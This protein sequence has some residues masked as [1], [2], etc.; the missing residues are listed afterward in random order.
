MLS[1]N[2]GRLVS[3]KK[4]NRTSRN[5]GQPAEYQ[6]SLG[7]I[8][9]EFEAF[10]QSTNLPPPNFDSLET[11]KSQAEERDRE[12]MN[13]LGPPPAG[14]TQRELWY[15]S[16]EGIKLRAKLY[17]PED[18]SK[19][20]SPL[21]VLFHGG[22]FCIGSPEGEEQTCRNLVAAFGATCISASYRLAPEH[23]FPC[24]P[25]DAWACIRWAASNANSWG[26]DPSAGF[27]VGGSSA[28]ANLASVVVHLARD[29]GLSPPL[30]G[31]YLAAP[32]ILPNS[33]VPARFKPFA[34]SHEQNRH[35][36]VVN[37]AQ[38]DMFMDGYKPDQDDGVWFASFNHP[39]GHAGLPPA[40]LQ[41]GGMDPF[42]DDAL[43]YEHELRNGD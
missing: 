2:D 39:R 24:A 1:K 34:L 22:G 42:R 20:N 7:Q 15:P 40:F 33:R 18:A 28:G 21:I 19:N 23:R 26:A 38:M 41:A 16:E 13:A 17:Q 10:L 35:A 29:E 14:V 43:I 30:T 25:R 27:I 5:V 3:R 11:F 12:G 37:V 6:L 4:V 36:L 31:Q 8:D 32:V 9:P